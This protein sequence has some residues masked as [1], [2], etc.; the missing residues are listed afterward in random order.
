M[1]RTLS[2][3]IGI[4]VLLWIVATALVIVAAPFIGALPLPLTVPA[5]VVL[6]VLVGRAFTAVYVERS[7]DR[8]PFSGLRLGG[9]VIVVQQILDAILVTAWGGRYPNTT[10]ETNGPVLTLLLGGYAAFLLGAAL[11]DVGRGQAPGR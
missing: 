5:V 8:R 2:L 7:R 1:N 3:Q 4:A 6:F 10:L 11:I 9:V